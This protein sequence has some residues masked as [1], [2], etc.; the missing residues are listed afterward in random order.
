MR[1]S[2]S[3][4]K[5]KSALY[6]GLSVSAPVEKLYGRTGNVKR[7]LIEKLT[8]RG[9]DLTLEQLSSTVQGQ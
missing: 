5:E 8:D 9:G 6:W 7:K 3:T 1:S 4:S 2:R